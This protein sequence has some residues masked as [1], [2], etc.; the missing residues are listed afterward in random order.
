MSLK[1]W[2]PEGRL[3]SATPPPPKHALG[4]RAGVKGLKGYSFSLTINKSN[5]PSKK[6]GGIFYAK[7]WTTDFKPA[8]KYILYSLDYILL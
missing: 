7:L 4:K 3:G 6:T 8:K 5:P 2:P 1:L